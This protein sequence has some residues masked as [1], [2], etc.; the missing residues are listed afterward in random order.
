MGKSLS[1]FRTSKNTLLGLATA[2]TC[3]VEA[4]LL[5]IEIMSIDEIEKQ[6]Q[7]RK[8]HYYDG[9]KKMANS[10]LLQLPNMPI[11]LHIAMLS[12]GDCTKGMMKN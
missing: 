7:S 3:S 1:S 4:E 5:E 6:K 10:I 2:F 11:D 12:V 8:K 9:I